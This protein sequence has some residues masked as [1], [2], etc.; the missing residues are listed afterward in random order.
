MKIKLLRCIPFCSMKGRMG[1]VPC[2][3]DVG[4]LCV[5]N[6]E[7]LPLSIECNEKFNLPNTKC[8][9]SWTAQ[10]TNYPLI[11]VKISTLLLTYVQ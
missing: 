2:V 8:L 6:E 10:L 11:M 9:V 1:G 7:N 4:Y 3:T 5:K